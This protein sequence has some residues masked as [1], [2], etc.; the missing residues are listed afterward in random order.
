MLTPLLALPVRD[1]LWNLIVQN[2]LSVF[3]LLLGTSAACKAVGVRRPS[4][5]AL[6]VL[7]AML[8]FSSHNLCL[9]LLTT[10]QS[11][12]PALGIFGLAIRFLL[13]R[14]ALAIVI[15]GALMVVGAWTNAGAALLV[16]CITAVMCGSR[17]VRSAAGRVFLGALVGIGA[18]RAV[19]ALDSGPL[20]DV[21][22]VHLV[23]FATIPATFDSFRVDVV[24]QTGF[25]FLAFVGVLWFVS[26]LSTSR[27]AD[28]G[29]ER[30]MLG[31]VALGSI[32][33]AILMVTMFQGLGRHMS[34]VFVVALAGPL[35]VLH[36]SADAD[37]FATAV[38]FIVASAVIAHSG[39]TTPRTLQRELV[40]SLGHGRAEVAYGRGAKAI[41]GDYWEVWTLAFATN[42]LHEQ[43]TG[44]RP[45]L[46]VAMRAERLIEL[47][48]R[49]L[50]ANSPVVVVPS[51][52]LGYWRSRPEL[53]DLGPTVTE[54]GTYSIAYVK[55]ND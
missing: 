36:R 54:F 30:T 24:R 15:G 13:Q 19:Q 46:P 11:Y 3:I 20:L 17:A 26:L 47:H 12:G 50:V 34:P 9:L 10:N 42:L 5:L 21:T 28:G 52:D 51:D 1:G 35:L 18:H 4:G 7:A 37:R 43:A 53:P 39:L 41:T 38:T 8:P 31:A 48:A 49:D 45:V 40:A 25:G 44:E 23:P 16:V 2:G 32:V 29:T 27:R 14:K 33:Y 55:G 22:G 6:A